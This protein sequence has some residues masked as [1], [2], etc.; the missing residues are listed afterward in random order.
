MN[1]AAKKRLRVSI[2]CFSCKRKKIKCDR[3]SPCGQCV[4][5][6]IECSYPLNRV[7]TKSEKS[8]INLPYMSSAKNPMM[9]DGDEKITKKKRV[10]NSENNITDIQSNSDSNTSINDNIN[11]NNNNIKYY[12]NIKNNV[13]NN[14]NLNNN[15]GLNTSLSELAS[16]KARINQI[17]FSLAGSSN[18]NSQSSSISS[19]SMR[20]PL[21]KFSPPQSR[22]LYGN[23]SREL[24]RNSSDLGS[25]SSNINISSGNNANNIINNSNHNN[26]NNNNTTINNRAHNHSD[27]T[28]YSHS[29]QLPP[30]NFKRSSNESSPRFSTTSNSL[31]D[32]SNNSISPSIK[33]ESSS[34][35][36]PINETTYETKY[37]NLNSMMGVLP[38]I[39]DNDYISFYE[40]YT[41]IHVH[42]NRTVNFGPF[43]WASI[44][45][46]D[47]GLSILW[48]SFNTIGSKKS[49]IFK[50]NATNV[51]KSEKNFESKLVLH[52]SDS[53]LVPYNTMKESSTTVKPINSD[54]LYDRT[55]S[56]GLAFNDGRLNR[57]LQLIEKIKVILPKKKVLWK[58]IRRFFSSVYPFM[59]FIDETSFILETTKLVGYE[60]FED[61]YITTLNVE[62]RIDL[63]H[64]GLLLLVIRLG[65]LSL[66]SNNASV[67]ERNL[68]STDPSPKAQEIKYLLMNPINIDVFEVAQDCL[69]QF[70]VLRRMSFQVLQ[71][72]FFIRLYNAF[73][74]E[75][76][77]IADCEPQTLNGVLIQMA[78]SLGL[79]REPDNF[80]DVLNDPKQNNLRRKMWYFLVMWDMFY[81]CTSGNPMLNDTIYHDVKIPFYEPGN[82]NISNIS[83]D[84]AVTESFG[85]SV[86]FLPKVRNILTLMLRVNGKAKM[87]QLT[88]LL[89]EVELE[90]SIKLGNLDEALKV[91]KEPEITSFYHRNVAV[92]SYFFMKTFFLTVYFYFHL[93]YESKNID[94]SFFYLKKL[95]FILCE[96]VMPYYFKLLEDNENLSDMIINPTIENLVHKANQVNFAFIIKVNFKI[97]QLKSQPD[98][99]HNCQTNQTYKDYFVAL[100]QLSSYIT[101]CAEI[102]IAAISKLS[103]RYYQAWKITKGHTYIL[104]SITSVDFYNTFSDKAQNIPTLFSYSQIEEINF[105][106]RNGLNK[107]ESR[108]YNNFSAG[109]APPKNQGDFYKMYS[110]SGS[111]ATDMDRPST[112]KPL[113]CMRIL[114]NL[115]ISQNQNQNQNQPGQRQPSELDFLQSEDID[116][117]WLQ[118]LSMKYDKQ[119]NNFSIPRNQNEKAFNNDEPTPG[120]NLWRM[121]STLS[122]TPLTPNSYDTRGISFEQSDIFSDFPFDQIFKP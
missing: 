21:P 87:S 3:M 74:P 95:L 19:E 113:D 67:N 107:I 43:A 20:P 14:N 116:K 89:S 48:D 23:H 66:F 90:T 114:D 99:V 1:G 121:D 80:Q 6:N 117:L 32:G 119:E 68:H 33:S 75:E 45:K 71:L 41:S 82:N 4:K 78:Y 115:D 9:F 97:H 28:S 10:A 39:D 56:L 100:C 16:L 102:S 15:N 79:N 30:L 5:A 88:K 94:L 46:K 98:H 63:A 55:L 118:M 106:L 60:S 35:L 108:D 57:E 109:I 47:K 103:N 44:M 93:H 11:N 17:E 61:E 70:Q 13:N 120:L 69:D 7:P 27:S 101:R 22:H 91:S 85:K 53:D 18:E 2:V 64:L 12:K 52:E 111:M 122:T 81:A 59:P 31:K 65:Y 77:D 40:G 29:I 86:I 92:K 76:G 8:D 42:G 51:T 73:S 58:L 25:T 24:S 112:S 96:D 110:S 36:Y 50:N 105:T 37:S 104:K 26:N 49:T 72:T 62:K 84:K 54:K 83:L 34:V 38:Y